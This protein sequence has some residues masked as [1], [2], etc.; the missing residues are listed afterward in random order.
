MVSP[1]IERATMFL[2]NNLLLVLFILGIIA[3]FIGFGF[4]DRNPGIILLGTGFLVALFVTIRKAID[5]FG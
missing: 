4:R 5:V 1:R 2:H 3:M